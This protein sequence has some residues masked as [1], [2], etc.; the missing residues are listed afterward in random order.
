MIHKML[1]KVEVTVV[2]LLLM[3]SVLLTSSSLDAASPR[4]NYLLYC[5]GCHGATGAGSPGNVP[6]LR[7]ELGRMLS[8]PEMRSYLVRIPGASQAPISDA[9]LAEV[10][11]WVL[12]EFNADTL[13][14]NFERLNTAEVSEAR[15][16]PLADPLKYRTQFWKTYD[17]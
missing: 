15:K 13:P 11:N 10:I 2:Q 3:G 7:D 16:S 14:A 4:I 17:N 1:N 5:T 9:E 6:T 12:E 8:V